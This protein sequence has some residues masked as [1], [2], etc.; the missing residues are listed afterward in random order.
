MLLSK[1]KGRSYGA[2]I[3][4]LWNTK[5]WETPVQLAFL[6][7]NFLLREEP[8]LTACIDCLYIQPR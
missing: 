5:T 6:I 4:S 8:G 1:I 7:V 3:E 2:N